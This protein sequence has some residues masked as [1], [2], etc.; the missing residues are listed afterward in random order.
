MAIKLSKRDRKELEEFVSEVLGKY[1]N[2]V[3]LIT[4]FGSA[5][6]GKLKKDSDMDILIVV[7]KN[8]LDMMQRLVR[9]A[10]R[11]ILKYGRLISLKVFNE[12]EYR[13]FNRLETPFMKN[14]EKEGIV[15]W[16]AD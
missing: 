11:L 4:L 9:V 10:T 14:V 15:L 12:N 6:Q 2:R 5:A 7:K 3:R 1:R 16:K 8:R 13:Y